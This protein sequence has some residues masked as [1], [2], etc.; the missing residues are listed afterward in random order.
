LLDR[1]GSRLNYVL[2][3]NELRGDTF[4]IFERSGEKEHALGLNARIISLRRLHETVINKI[5]AG[6][7]SFWAAKNK[8]DHDATGLGLLERQ[9]V[10]VWLNNAYEQIDSLHV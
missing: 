10:K 7:T 5:D 6:S 4:D 8:S 2:V 1:F 3:L 9:R